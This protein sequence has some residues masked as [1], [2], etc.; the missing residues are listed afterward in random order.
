M[1][2]IV[3]YH[4]IASA[5]AFAEVSVCAA[6]PAAQNPGED[7][8]LFLSPCGAA[9]SVYKPSR[10]SR[11]M[12]AVLAPISGPTLSRPRSGASNI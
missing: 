3:P 8:P 2:M 9:S 12:G 6:R 5:A 11:L 10:W 7:R 1:S 4:D